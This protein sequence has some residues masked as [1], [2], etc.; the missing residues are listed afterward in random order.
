MAWLKVQKYCEF[1]DTLDAQL[2]KQISSGVRSQSLRDKLWSEDLTLEQ[3]LAK[4]HLY[5]QKQESLDVIESRQRNN[6]N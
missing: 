1:R 6:V 3:I 4:C 5:E 2:H